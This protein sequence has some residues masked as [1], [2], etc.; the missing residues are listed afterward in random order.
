MLSK[1]QLA[2][3]VTTVAF[4]VAAGLGGAL[5]RTHETA[6]KQ[7][8]LVLYLRAEQTKIGTLSKQN[9]QKL[10]SEVARLEQELRAAQTAQ[11]QLTDQLFAA[12]EDAA[13]LLEEL[14]IAEQNAAPAHDVTPAP[15]PY[16]TYLTL[17][18]AVVNGQP[19][20]TEWQAMQQQFATMDASIG[21]ALSPY[22]DGL[23]TSTE[24]Q[25]QLREIYEHAR[26]VAQEDGILSRLREVITIRKMDKT[27]V[28][29]KTAILSGSIKNAAKLVRGDSAYQDWIAVYDARRDAIRALNALEQQLAGT[30]G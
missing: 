10:A 6:E 8:K 5:Y 17:R 7:Q 2:W 12:E 15:S 23:T 11:R 25:S 27:D 3:S 22:A 13:F 20:H 26:H 21:A 18:R 28:A 19:Y 30:H 14:E 4:L 1:T 16:I 29:L 24:L 9:R